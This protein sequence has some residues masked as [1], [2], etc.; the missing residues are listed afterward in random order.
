VHRFNQRL[1]RAAIVLALG[2]TPLSPA[3]AQQPPWMTETFTV[4][5][6]LTFATVDSD[7]I[8]SDQPIDLERDIGL[9][10]TKIVP[11]VDIRWRW[12]DNQR[13]RLEASYFSLSRSGSQKV[14][15][16]QVLVP[17]APTGVETSLATDFDINIASL[18]YGYSWLHDARKELGIMAGLDFIV[19]D[20]ESTA[21]ITG[22]P[23]NQTF[24]NELVEESFHAPFPTAGAYFNYRLPGGFILNSRLQYFDMAFDSLE[25][26]ILRGHARIQYS[27]LDNWA[28]ISA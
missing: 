20:A 22:L 27:E 8:A 2:L 17:S 1:T 3:M 28:P 13:H 26:E 9:D 12:S 7:V 6:G 24:R 25:G 15:F 16:A 4:R 10:S 5:T 23:G 19:I 18:T 21:T 14:N 11:S